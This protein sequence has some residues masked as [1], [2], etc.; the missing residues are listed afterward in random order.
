MAPRASSLE[1][2][3]LAIVGYGRIGKEIAQRAKPFGP[4][5]VA[6]SRTPV[7]DAL[8][9][10]FHP[11]GELHQVLGTADA[12]AI[13]IALTPQ[14]RHLFD[15]RAFAACKRGSL[16]VNI[17]RG[18]V[19]DQAALC[20]ALASGQLGAAGLDVTD[21]EPLPD[22]DPLWHAPNILISPHYA[23]A[24]SPKSIE[25]IAASVIDNLELARTPA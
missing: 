24:G 14:T 17:A 11:L 1:G 6:V 20:E 16:L 8:I 19:I 2:A 7:S 15:A 25:R 10:E 3:T 13:A 9:D 23:G 5:I 22:G 12:V 18:G 4:R 21:P